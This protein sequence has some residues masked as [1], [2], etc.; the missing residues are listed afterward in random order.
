MY[1]KLAVRKTHALG[2][3]P[4]GRACAHAYRLCRTLSSGPTKSLRRAE[5]RSNYAPNTCSRVERNILNSTPKIGSSERIRLRLVVPSLLFSFAPS[6]HGKPD[7][8]TAA[9]RIG[10]LREHQIARS[11]HKHQP[12]GCQSRRTRCRRLSILHGKSDGLQD[13]FSQGEP[14]WNSSRR[15]TLPGRRM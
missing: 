8:A 14:L 10:L 2:A 5:V 13:R 1:K 11:K 15:N 3:G 6:S 12:N 4:L 7:R 9:F